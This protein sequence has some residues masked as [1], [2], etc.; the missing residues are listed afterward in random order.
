MHLIEQV[1]LTHRQYLID[2]SDFSA[3]FLYFDHRLCKN[4]MIFMMIAS[5]SI[6]SIWTVQMALRGHLGR[7]CDP[8]FVIS[9]EG[10][11]SRALLVKSFE[12]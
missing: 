11:R 3:Q 5:C 2:L 12:Y 8:I 9:D 7:D 1:S 6:F 4:R 10:T